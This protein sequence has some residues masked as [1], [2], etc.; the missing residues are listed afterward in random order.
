MC[1]PMQNVIDP[2]KIMEAAQ[3]HD[4]S[5]CVVCR[6][7]L[8]A[9]IS[10]CFHFGQQ[11]G[12]VSA[13]QH[14]EGRSR[15][16]MGSGYS[17]SGSAA[18]PVQRNED[19]KKIRHT[20]TFWRN[21]FTVDDGPLRSVDDDANKSFLD[22][23]NKGRVPAEFVGDED[24]YVS[25]ID[26]HGQDYEPPA[27]AAAKAF[28]GTGHSLGGSAAPSAAASGATV[29]APTETIAVDESAPVTTIQVLIRARFSSSE[30]TLECMHHNM[31]SNVLTAEKTPG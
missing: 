1:C 21:G 11:N 6:C 16:F 31:R 8:L 7:G 5:W 4:I 12:A 3:V 10:I 30:Y 24:P 19:T 26:K 14:E 23:I 29:Q 15:A 27:G 2:K 18:A 20:I 25:L 9:V 22:D 13:S 28:E 17:L